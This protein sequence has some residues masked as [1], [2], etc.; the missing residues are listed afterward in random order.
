M[1]FLFST[2]GTVLCLN[3]VMLIGRDSKNPDV[4]SKNPW[5]R[6]GFVRLIGLVSMH[7][8]M[9]LMCLLCLILAPPPRI[10]PPK[11][12]INNL[13]KLLNFEIWMTTVTHS[14]FSIKSNFCLKDIPTS[15][16][17]CFDEEKVHNRLL[18]LA[19]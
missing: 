17:L 11:M 10:P 4:D 18:T 7:L 3:Q 9:S 12:P 15:P 14:E 1:L 5:P 2:S 6:R 16:G 19:Q 13:V 8:I